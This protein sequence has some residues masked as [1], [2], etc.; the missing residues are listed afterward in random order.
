M[1]K[2]REMK[3]QSKARREKQ[4]IIELLDKYGGNITRVAEEMEVARNTVYR[5]MKQYGIE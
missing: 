1:D 2:R 5:K 3:K 4:Q